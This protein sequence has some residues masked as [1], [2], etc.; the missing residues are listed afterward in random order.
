MVRTARSEGR[1]ALVTGG[2]RGI[3][4]AVV[5]MLAELGMDV[6]LGSRDVDAG[7]AAARGLDL[8]GITPGADRRGRS[9]ERRGGA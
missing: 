3:G 4:L 5:R 2:N 8:P 6:F 9:G 7:A 1:R